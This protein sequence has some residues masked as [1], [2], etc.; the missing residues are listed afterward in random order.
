LKSYKKD[1]IR[2]GNV[3]Y[4]SSETSRFVNSRKKNN[5]KI[6]YDT[7]DISKVYLLD[8]DNKTYVEVPSISPP[9]DEVKGMSRALYE[10]IRKELIKQGIIN[11]QQIP[12]T[13]N[14][15]EGKRLIRERY[16]EMIKK[17]APTFSRR[18]F[19]RW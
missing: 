15:I 17:S 11:K 16:N 7:Q 9:A 8:L 10:A 1:G 13:A 4:A 2:E 19:V 12:G 5:C 6:K 14:I 3:R 18:A